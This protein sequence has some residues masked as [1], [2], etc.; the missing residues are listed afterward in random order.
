MP[1]NY[2]DTECGVAGFSR[3][4]YHTEPHSHFSIELAF[5]ISGS[6]TFNTGNREYGQ[7]QAAIVGS[8]VQHTFSCLCGECQLYFIDPTGS[9]GE[10]I[11]KSY[12]A[13]SQDLVIRRLSRMG[14][15][16]LLNSYALNKLGFQPHRV[17]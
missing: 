10:D 3:K 1:I 15:W 6:L 17:A 13:Q 7:I 9:V 14:L 11:L 12:P 16:M 2:F 8:N 5:S 4:D